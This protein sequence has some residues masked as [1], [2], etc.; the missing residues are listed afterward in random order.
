MKS[1]QALSRTAAVSSNWITS[2]GTHSCF[3]CMSGM[4]GRNLKCYNDIILSLRDGTYAAIH[5]VIPVVQSLAG[6]LH[7]LKHILS[8]FDSHL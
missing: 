3:L 7:P 1:I 4:Y 2:T 6:S 8:P 5:A